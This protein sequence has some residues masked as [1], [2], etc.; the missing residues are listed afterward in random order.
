LWIYLSDTVLGLFVRD[1]DVITR[2][3]T[4]KGLLFIATT[5]T[6]LYI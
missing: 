4:Y 6:L 2:I 3:A 5:A 1:P